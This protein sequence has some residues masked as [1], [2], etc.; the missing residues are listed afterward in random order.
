MLE[1]SLKTKFSQDRFISS[2]NQQNSAMSTEYSCPEKMD[3]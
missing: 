3:T 2:K 1:T